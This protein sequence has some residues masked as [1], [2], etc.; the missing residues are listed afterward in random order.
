[1]WHQVKRRSVKYAL[2]S[3]ITSSCALTARKLPAA[4]LKGLK[5]QRPGKAASFPDKILRPGAAPLRTPALSVRTVN[6][7][8]KRRSVKYALSSEITSFVP[9]DQAAFEM[10]SVTV[11]NLGPDFKPDSPASGKYR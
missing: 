1:M 3:E 5:P 10:M 7:Q 11:R 6:E 2:S 4:A 8:V 9:R